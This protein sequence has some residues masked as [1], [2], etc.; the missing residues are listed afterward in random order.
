[1][2]L[3]TM[4]RASSR[5]NNGSWRFCLHYAFVLLSLVCM[6]TLAAGLNDTGQ[7]LCY[8]AVGVEVACSDAGFPGQD[9][10]FGRDPA[11][12][13]GA[14]T[15]IGGGQA[16]FDF[17]KLGADGQPLGIQNG[18]WAT[19]GSPNYFDNG[20]EGAGTKWV[21]VRDNVTD[22]IWEVKTNA[23]PANLRDQ[24]WTYTWYN[25]NVSTNGGLVGQEDGGAGQNGDNCYNTARCDTEKYVADVNA[26]ALC[27]YAD[28]RLPSR[29]EL[30]SIVH[31]D[32]FSPAIDGAYFANTRSLFYWSIETWTYN[33]PGNATSAWIVN[34]NNGEFGTRA[35]ASSYYVRLVRGGQ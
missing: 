13:A 4:T 26:A 23:T 5:A 19:T 1:M 31:H 11:S 33:W 18:S 22:L 20:S 12:T 30:L 7:K 21:C 35:K 24:D 28:W 2:Q 34:F 9:A 8:N 6:P 10:R 29:K 27:G 16:G 14:L 17:T 32:T 3:T 15:K 25:S